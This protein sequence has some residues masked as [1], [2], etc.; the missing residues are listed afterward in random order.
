MTGRP[1][2]LVVDD[3]PDDV[4]IARRSLAARFDVEAVPTAAEG[5][6]KLKSGR[7][8]FALVVL[9]YR[10]GDSNALA[11]LRESAHGGAGPPVI[12]VS[13]HADPRVAEAARTLGAFE[14]VP[15]DAIAGGA[16]ARTA[17]RA[18]AERVPPP[19]QD[20][21]GRELI[22][23]RM[24][25]GLWAVDNVGVIVFAN[26]ALERLLAYE[27]N[28]LLGV[29]IERVLSPEGLNQLAGCLA[30]GEA[31]VELELRSCTGTP[32]PALVSPSPLV[33]P[34]GHVAVVRDFRDLRRRIGALEDMNRRLREGLGE[35]AVQVL[36]NVGNAVASLDVRVSDLQQDAAEAS[37][38]L[39]ALGLAGGELERGSP[40]F[41]DR[42][43]EL[44]ALVRGAERTLESI[45]ASVS[46]RIA[47]IRSAVSHVSRGLEHARAFVRPGA[48]RPAESALEL[49][50]AIENAVALVRDLA[51][52]RGLD[53]SITAAV[54]AKTPRLPIPGAGFE[55]LLLNLLKNALES[56][57][58]RAA[59]SADAPREI[60]V[61]ARLID[62][63]EGGPEARQ[64]RLGLLVICVRDTGE[65]V[66]P[67]VASRAFEF[68]FSTKPEGTGL[69]L[70]ASAEFVERLGGTIALR[71]EG[72]DR[73]AEV[74]LR[75]PIEP[76]P[77]KPAATLD[78]GAPRRAAA[79]PP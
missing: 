74:E 62:A 39:H 78:D 60:H 49:A 43:R 20:Q 40:S 47:S 18:I 5:L 10:L 56:V 16:L 1:I 6:A 61:D 25:E 71:S 53:V 48:T 57:A 45:A 41:D 7:D 35:V 68:G 31:F 17:E 14:F 4:E 77:A 69:G 26:P 52:A 58:A 79:S 9:D 55:Q 59:R 70:H 2:A 34:G 38:A 33:D 12:V 76:L 21:R 54:P 32:V 28:A 24:S 13:G 3:D 19:R 30:R 23:Q 44:I 51:R 37:T 46:E 50:P 65:G 42:T 64:E 63:V 27:E 22:F 73:G 11:F 36:H 67:E 8:R 15:K 75:I 66:S 29:G 72:T